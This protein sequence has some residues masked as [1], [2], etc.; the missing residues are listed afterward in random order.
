M[1]VKISYLIFHAQ[2]LY[3]CSADYGNRQPQ[4]H[5]DDCNLRTKDTH[6]KYQAPQIHHRG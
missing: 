4:H 1:S 6:K 3:H 5:I 2:L